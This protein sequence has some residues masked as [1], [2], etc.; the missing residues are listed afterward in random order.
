MPIA[1][2]IAI[3]TMHYYAGNEVSD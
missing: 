3:Q 2:A 1:V